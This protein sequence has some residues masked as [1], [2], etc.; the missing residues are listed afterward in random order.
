MSLRGWEYGQHIQETTKYS[1][2]LLF[3]FW[4]TAD[5]VDK[6]VTVRFQMTLGVNSLVICKIK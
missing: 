4:V 1:F 3:F 6:W 2:W 5:E